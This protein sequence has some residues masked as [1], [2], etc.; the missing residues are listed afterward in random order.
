MSIINILL[1]SSISINSLRKSPFI[2][3]SYEGSFISSLIFYLVPGYTRN[4]SNLT[5]F[6]LPV[7]TKYNAAAS[8][9]YIYI[10]F[11]VVVK[12]I[13]YLILI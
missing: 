2:I 6:N 10:L 7:L 13:I 9:P 11:I 1:N 3:S 8:V 4:V 12:I 5:D